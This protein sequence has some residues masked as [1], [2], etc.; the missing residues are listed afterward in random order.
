MSTPS[1]LRNWVDRATFFTV[2]LC[3]CATSPLNSTLTASK[4]V[5]QNVIAEQSSQ[6]AA[7]AASEASAALIQAPPSP[8]E[9]P[10]AALGVTSASADNG[11][12]Q[13]PDERRAAS[14]SHAMTEK[15]DAVADRIDTLERQVEWFQ[16]DVARMQ[17]LLNHM[18]SGDRVTAVSGQ[19]MQRDQATLHKYIAD[20]RSSVDAA[21]KSAA[22]QRSTIDVLTRRI[23]ALEA[24]RAQE[25]AREMQTLD[26]VI[27]GMER[28]LDVRA[29]RPPQRQQFSQ[30][31][32]D[33]PQ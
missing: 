30:E 23:E 9:L 7:A 5:P 24:L 21:E 27:E 28:L 13:I 10:A 32:E 17:Q 18:Q 19:E 31:G 22:A 6:S 25:H 15:S 4:I 3:G 14:S 8:P 11:G 1:L 26:Q 12:S 29:N 16:S 20:L 2:L 33:V